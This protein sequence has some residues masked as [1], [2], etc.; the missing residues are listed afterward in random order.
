[1]NITQPSLFLLLLNMH[2]S[3]KEVTTVLTTSV[4]EKSHMATS[5]V[6]CAS[7]QDFLTILHFLFHGVLHK[8]KLHLGELK[9]KYWNCME[10][11]TDITNSI[12]AKG[13]TSWCWRTNKVNFSL[14]KGHVETTL[15][16]LQSQH[17]LKH[18]SFSGLVD[19]S[20]LVLYY[21]PHAVLS[22]L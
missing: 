16:V 4:L 11:I 15:K 19:L 21:V 12:M 6:H 20:K 5:F 18:F 10:N 14:E 13:M 7:L 22:I 2:F 17:E 8:A 3:H 9:R 1:M